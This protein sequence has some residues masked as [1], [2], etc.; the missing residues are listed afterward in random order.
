MN[1]DLTILA[2]AYLDDVATGEE[3]SGVE[4]SPDLLAEVEQLRLVRALLADVEASAISLREQHLA[5]ALGAWDRL[6]QAER[7]GAARDITPQGIDP[8]TAAAAATISTPAPISL[9][10]R[11]RSKA[12]RWMTAAAAALALVLAGGI[13]LQ[14]VSGGNNDDVSFSAA[15]APSDDA[16]EPNS[17]AAIAEEAAEELQQDL[18]SSVEVVD[19]TEGVV[20]DAENNATDTEVLFGD[21]TLGIDID[22]EA[23]PKD[24]D[25]EILA[26]P[27]QLAIFASD[28]VGAPPSPD[29]PAST[30]VA[31]D[32][33]SEAE[34]LSEAE[35][36]TEVFEFPLCGGADYVVGPAEYRGEPV[37]VGIDE[38][39]D[40]AIAYKALDC[41]VIARASLP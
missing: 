34:S 39:R 38:S 35:Q 20:D 25:L 41:S 2:S 37:V 1:E 5:A 31:S 17:S 26:T 12:A 18:E 9:E 8:A 3:R 21:D 24:A 27:E 4:N 15:D 32:R 36:A 22:A 28:A 7:T 6:P 29:I 40:L 19:D 23:P 30:D 16:P 10:G 33:A 13:I 11:G 14:S